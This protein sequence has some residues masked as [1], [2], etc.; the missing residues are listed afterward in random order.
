MQK[1]ARSSAG[2]LLRAQDRAIFT[3]VAKKLVSR[4]G[5]FFL[6]RTS[7]CS[8][9]FSILKPETVCI[10]SLKLPKNYSKLP[11]LYKRKKIPFDWKKKPICWIFFLSKIAFCLPKHLKDQCHTRKSEFPVQKTNLNSKNNQKCKEFWVFI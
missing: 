3:K 7:F 11:L 8:A 6:K 4:S 5:F 2:W 1:S 10:L 9:S